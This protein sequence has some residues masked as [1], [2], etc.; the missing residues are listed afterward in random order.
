MAE[1]K[2]EALKIIE[3]GLKELESAKGS[4][5][6]GVQKLSRSAKLLNEDEIVAWSEIQLGSTRYVSALQDFSEKIDEEYKK[7]EK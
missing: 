5:T 7:E 6:V 4:V 1:R 2:A 3:E